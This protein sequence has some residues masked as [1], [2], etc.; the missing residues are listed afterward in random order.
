[1]Y[2]ANDDIGV[3]ERME[4]EKYNS[5]QGMFPS[6]EKKERVQQ[7]RGIVGLI[8]DENLNDLFLKK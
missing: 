7:V 4:K 5:C 1:M 6:N 8:L 3:L 2:E